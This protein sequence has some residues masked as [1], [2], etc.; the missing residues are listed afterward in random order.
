MACPSCK[1]TVR[2]VDGWD[3]K[4]PPQLCPDCQAECRGIRRDEPEKDPDRRRDARKW[5]DDEKAK[6]RTR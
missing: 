6:E 1:R 5:I 3:G 2:E 4:H